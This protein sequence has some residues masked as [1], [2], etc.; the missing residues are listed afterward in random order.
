M[1]RKRWSGSLIQ[2]RYNVRSASSWSKYHSRQYSGSLAG[3]RDGGAYCGLVHVVR[4]RPIS[5][6]ATDNKPPGATAPAVCS[7][8]SMQ[9]PGHHTAALSKPC[10]LQGI[11]MRNI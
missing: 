4:C 6:K 10:V 3:E 7:K 8:A 9:L 1:L 11:T 2:I 5:S